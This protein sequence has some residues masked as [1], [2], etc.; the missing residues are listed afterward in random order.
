M[1]ALKDYLKKYYRKL[2]GTFFARYYSDLEATPIGLFTE[3]LSGDIARISIN[4]NYTNEGLI[5]AWETLFNLHIEKHGLPQSYLDYMSVMSKVVT[6]YDQA[7]NK[8]KRWLLVKAKIYE[9]E[10]KNLMLGESESIEVTCAKISKFLGF[11]VRADKCSVSE[12]Y[13]YIKLMSE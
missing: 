2:L 3:A 5:R 10:A 9:I 1:K 13:A 4:G 12:F 8:G 6:T 11:P 7:L